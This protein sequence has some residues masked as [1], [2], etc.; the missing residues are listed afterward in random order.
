MDGILTP[1]RAEEWL[2]H[3]PHK[4]LMPN[5]RAA[6]A[7]AITKAKAKGIAQDGK[8]RRRDYGGKPGGASK[9]KQQTAQGKEEEKLWKI[10]DDLK[11]RI[12]L[13]RKKATNEHYFVAPVEDHWECHP[14]DAVNG[15][16]TAIKL[17]FDRHFICHP[18][19]VTRRA[20]ANEPLQTIVR[21]LDAECQTAPRADIHK[22]F[23]GHPEDGVLYID[24]R[25]DEWQSIKVTAKGWKAGDYS[26]EV[27]FERDSRG[28]PL[29]VPVREGTFEG[30]LLPLVN[31]RGQ[32]EQTFP[33]L[34]SFMVSCLLTDEENPGLSI[35]GP[36]GAAKTTLAKLLA[37]T[38]DPRS[39]QMIMIPP[40]P[41]D[42]F[43]SVNNRPIVAYDNI[44]SLPGWLSDCLAA[45]VSGT[46]SGDRQLHTNKEESNVEGRKPF[47]LTSI[48]NIVTRPD[49]RSRIYPIELR[50]IAP[51]DRRDDIRAL[52]AAAQPRILGAVLNAAV[53]GLAHYA[54]TR[55]PEGAR[56]MTSHRWSIACSHATKITPEQM[57]EAIFGDAKI[58]AADSIDDSVIGAPLL[59]MLEENGGK[60]G[61]LTPTEFHE[62]FTRFK[63]GDAPPPK[64]WP[65][66][67]NTMSNALR[68]IQS[69]L[70]QIG[71]D[72][73]VGVLEKRVAEGRKSRR[74]MTTVERRTPA[75]SDDPKPADPKPTPPP[76]EDDDGID[77]D[78]ED[79][80]DDGPVDAKPNGHAK[81]D[82][83]E[84]AYLKGCFDTGAS[85]LAPADAHT[86]MRGRFGHKTDWKS[87]VSR[88]GWNIREDGLYH[89]E[90]AP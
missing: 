81:P 44:T 14:L 83:S 33:L 61:P 59:E 34:V 65:S 4:E 19:N 36:Y 6:I 62:A 24:L 80:L 42:L 74:K 88:Q 38:L 64:F 9:P 25:N 72:L 40:T 20:C 21:T 11:S 29:P 31:L 27:L 78:L 58:G 60:I 41:K 1:E 35:Y 15:R 56:A 55:L 26:D 66:R 82:H 10:L 22:S 47:I 49:L 28:A 8:K 63:W 16:R 7:G 77:L 57:H 12:K 73:E 86:F 84:A 23:A 79:M 67:P 45:I 3:F 5:A 50:P 17:W 54:E 39:P 52:S 71:V 37:G 68:K 53:S 51:T 18:L 2:A 75:P 48:P 69:S 70:A 89:K 43:A 13:V 46:G 76:P 85:T 87:A 90:D 32:P 30:D